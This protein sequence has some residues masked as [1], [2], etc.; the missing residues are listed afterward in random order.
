V[1]APILDAKARQLAQKVLSL[2]A[3]I[4]REGAS[5]SFVFR[6]IAA[7][8]DLLVAGVSFAMAKKGLLADRMLAFHE[9]AAAKS[10]AQLDERMQALVLTLTRLVG[11]AFLCVGLMLIATAAESL[12]RPHFFGRFVGPGIGAIFCVGLT[13]LN[14]KLHKQTSAPTPWKGGL[15]AV[16]L[17]TVSMLVS[18]AD[19]LA[20]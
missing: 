13:W 3:P 2:D 19:L 14:F 7:V 6:L 20:R 12:H 4:A 17:L 9:K 16:A 11:L 18:A 5:M 15:A 1:E 10:W 8:C